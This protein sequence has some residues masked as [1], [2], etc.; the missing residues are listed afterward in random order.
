MALIV[1]NK[2]GQMTRPDPI[3]KFRFDSNSDEGCN[4]IGFDFGQLDHIGSWSD[5]VKSKIQKIQSQNKHKSSFWSNPIQTYSDGIGLDH[6]FELSLGYI[7]SNQT[8]LKSDWANLNPN[9]PTP[10][11]K[12]AIDS[13]I[14]VVIYQICFKR[15]HTTTECTI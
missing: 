9:L 3:Q 1:A 12:G 6:M 14:I 11:G 10:S 5:R 15:N 4:L 7:F 2:G 13:N 8:N